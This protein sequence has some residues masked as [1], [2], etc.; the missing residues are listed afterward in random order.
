MC[1]FIETYLKMN[2]VKRIEEDKRFGIVDGQLT[3]DYWADKIERENILTEAMIERA[4]EDY[5]TEICKLEQQIN[6]LKIL[7]QKIEKLGREKENKITIYGLHKTHDGC[8]RG[9]TKDYEFIWDTIK[10]V[11]A[12]KP[13]GGNTWRPMIKG[14]YQQAQYIKQQINVFIIKAANTTMD[15][16]TQDSLEDLDF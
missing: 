2:N 4:I 1:K 10:N 12:M 8:Y 14:Y 5:D 16:S 11:P 3:I 15:L 13:N 7:K 9:Y 6:E